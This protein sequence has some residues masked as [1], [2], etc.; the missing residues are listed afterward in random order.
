MIAE[1][2]VGREAHRAELSTRLLAL[3]GDQSS[4]E[5]WDPSLHLLVLAAK[6]GPTSQ[7]TDEMRPKNVGSR[8]P[9]P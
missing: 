4:V 6:E 5:K 7:G 1:R 2:A 8:R 9:R 3:S